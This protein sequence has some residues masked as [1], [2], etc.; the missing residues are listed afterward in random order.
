MARCGP[1]RNWLVG[2]Y[3]PGNSRLASLKGCWQRTRACPVKTANAES[4]AGESEI[5]AC[6]PRG[7]VLL[8][9]AGGRREGPARH[10]PEPVRRRGGGH[11]GGGGRGYGSGRL[12][13]R[14]GTCTPPAPIDQSAEKSAC[15]A[16]DTIE[17]PLDAVLRSP[18]PRRRQTPGATHY[19]GIGPG[20]PASERP[21]ILD[22]L[23][24]RHPALVRTTL[25]PLFVVRALAR[26][27]KP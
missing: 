8:P 20:R 6:T 23:N 27:P 14:R 9:A 19:S 11:L 21:R 4:I 1:S 13:R 7:S 25:S 2:D 10:R 16:M 18:G 26:H 12:V 15:R 24:S 17:R 5:G 22:R 3:Y